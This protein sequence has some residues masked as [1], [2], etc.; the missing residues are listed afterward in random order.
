M[1]R[2]GKNCIEYF[3]LVIKNIISLV[4]SIYEK[5][6]TIKMDRVLGYCENL[7]TNGSIDLVK[8]PI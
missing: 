3:E 5:Y 8:S 2:Y 6:V 7:R 1:K 4:S